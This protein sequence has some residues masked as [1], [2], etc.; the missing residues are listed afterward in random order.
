M[1]DRFSLSGVRVGGW[2]R[3]GGGVEE[4]ECRLQDQDALACTSLVHG[5]TTS[6]IQ[7][8]NIP[9]NANRSLNPLLP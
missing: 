8:I 2:W 3:R 5:L 4:R 7:K 1:G 6:S 9:K